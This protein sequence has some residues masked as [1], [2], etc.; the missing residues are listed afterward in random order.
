MTHCGIVQAIAS[1][2]ATAG[3]VAALT[4]K[5]YIG[6]SGVAA[7]LANAI[8]QAPRPTRVSLVQPSWSPS[9]AG[10]AS[11]L[12][13]GIGVRSMCM[14]QSTLADVTGVAGVVLV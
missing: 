5:P 3:A 7:Y 14:W 1:G 8:G 9:R 12:R 13:A 10:S 6:A 2:L 4:A 11:P